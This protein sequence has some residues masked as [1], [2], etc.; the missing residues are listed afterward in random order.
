[1]EGSHFFN[2]RGLEGN[3]KAVRDNLGNLETPWRLRRSSY[4][5]IIKISNLKTNLETVHE[6]RDRTLRIHGMMGKT[7]VLHVNI[8]Q[9]ERAP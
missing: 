6:T 2:A 1:M 7:G 3:T 4:D 9:E 5:V 8:L